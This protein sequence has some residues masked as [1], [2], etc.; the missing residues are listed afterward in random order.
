METTEVKMDNTLEVMG[1]ISEGFDDILTD[2]ALEFASKLHR[3][4]NPTR[5]ELLENRK[6]R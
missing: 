2:N 4:F 3:H 6:N 5:L 1:K